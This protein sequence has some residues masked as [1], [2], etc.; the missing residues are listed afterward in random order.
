MAAPS[1][2]EVALWPGRA[3]AVH[4]L[5]PGD[6]VVAQRDDRME[7]L[8]G[9]CVAI[10][11]TDPRRTIGAMC[12]I[13]HSRPPVSGVTTSGA[14]AETALR[15]MYTGLGAYGINASLCEAWVFGGGNMFPST[16]SQRHVGADNADW[17]LDALARDG[18]RVL[19]HDV[20]G[21]VYRKLAWTV[22]VGA[23]QV[24]AVPV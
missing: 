10:V 24:V 6:V 7:T 1:R 23:P 20:G 3:P 22:G 12:H 14:Y 5:H 4:T 2:P 9:S 19:D 13:V 21:T 8:L 15:R 18:V 11:M 16:F 17:A